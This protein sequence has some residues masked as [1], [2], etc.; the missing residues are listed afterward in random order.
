M[1]NAGSLS[2]CRRSQGSR[3]HHIAELRVFCFPIWSYPMY[4]LMKHWVKSHLDGCI[5][6][7]RYECRDYNEECG[8]PVRQSWCQSFN[9]DLVGSSWVIGGYGT[10]YQLE[11]IPNYNATPDEDMLYVRE[12]TDGKCHLT[13]HNPHN[14]CVHGSS[15]NFRANNFTTFAKCLS[16]HCHDA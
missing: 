2:Y 16:F 11:Y 4:H 15:K 8:D 12:V 1:C 5:G 3:P 10:I 7:I 13:V 6:E 14:T 9:E